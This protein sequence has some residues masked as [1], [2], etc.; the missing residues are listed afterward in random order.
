[1]LRLRAGCA[2]RVVS[3]PVA[4][5]LA[6]RL[7]LARSDRVSR[8][9]LLLA[10]FAPRLTTALPPGLSAVSPH[11][12]RAGQPQARAGCACRPASSRRPLSRRAR[13]CPAFASPGRSPAARPSRPPHSVSLPPPS[14]RPCRAARTRRRGRL[15][16]LSPARRVRIGRPWARVSRLRGC[17]GRA[18]RVVPSASARV[19]LRVGSASRSGAMRPRL[20][21]RVVLGRVRAEGGCRP[22]P[23][24]A[25]VSRKPASADP[26]HRL[27]LAGFPPAA[28]RRRP[29]LA[30]SS[31]RKLPGGLF[32][33]GGLTHWAERERRL[34]RI[35]AKNGH[36]LRN[37]EGESERRASAGAP[38]V[39][40]H[41][42][43]CVRYTRARG[44]PDQGYISLGISKQVARKRQVL[45]KEG[46]RRGCA[47]RARRPASS[48]WLPSRAELQPLP[49]ARAA[50]PQPCCPGLQRC[51]PAAY[52]CRPSPCR[53]S[54][55]A[56]RARR[57]AGRRPSAALVPRPTVVL[58]APRL[59]EG[60]SRGAPAV[61]PRS[62]LPPPALPPG[63]SAVPLRRVGGGRRLPG[64]SRSMPPRG[65]ALRPPG[66]QMPPFL[67]SKHGSATLS[68]GVWLPFASQIPP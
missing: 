34:A 9:V 26:P 33:G 23:A 39:V 32:I 25:P 13:R 35:P 64:A 45:C 62:R 7:G 4:F 24:F 47:G 22:R 30:G 14:A 59:C 41:Q 44:R 63:P 53:A 37:S 50:R 52:R 15:P 57:R 46:R 58:A 42:K 18:F 16:S 49:R 11:R 68:G 55:R 27:R 61:A 56:A 40:W 21:R 54:A 10:A 2:F 5:A 38:R 48:C 65:V 66:R 67:A 36:L 20:E 12:V 28:A 6:V 8:G 31:P 1:M 51:L 43:R 19:R 3:P 17:V 60:L 29:A